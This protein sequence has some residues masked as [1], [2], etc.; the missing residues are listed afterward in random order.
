MDIK[1]KFS[2]LAKNISSGA[3]QVAKKS[4]EIVE[5]S[6]TNMSI[7]SN[8]NKIIELYAKIGEVIFNRYKDG[9]EIPQELKELCKDINNLEEVNEKLIGKI[10]KIKKLKKCSNCGEEMKTEITYCQK[11]GLKQN[12]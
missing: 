6:K 10:N 3:S 2:G 4:E 1:G 8:E 7:D 5:V 9:K 12:N 11:C